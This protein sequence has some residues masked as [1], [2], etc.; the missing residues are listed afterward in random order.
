MSIDTGISVTLKILAFTYEERVF[1]KVWLVYIHMS[2]V[3]SE[4]A[5]TTLYQMRSFSRPTVSVSD[6]N[7][8]IVKI[9]IRMSTIYASH[10]GPLS[11]FINYF[12]S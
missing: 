7:E 3:T 2:M 11:V 5:C 9:F 4:K 6:V 12:P 1:F 8:N 10:C